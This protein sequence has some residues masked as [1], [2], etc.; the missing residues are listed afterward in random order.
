GARAGRRGERQADFLGR[1]D[2]EY[3]THG[4]R[5]AGIRVDHVVE[6][7]HLAIVVGQDRE[8]DA[9]ALGV[10]DVVDPARMRIH[11]VDRYGQYLHV[12]LG[13]FVAKLGREAEFRGA[14]GR[15]VGWVREEHAPAVA[16]ILMKAY[17]TG[18]G[19]LFKVGGDV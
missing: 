5:G 18:R 15:E 4:G 1:I 2:D 10:I 7:G 19:I 9:G 8:V 14:Y 12:A 3:R 17:R 16:Q 11:G 6:V 13:K